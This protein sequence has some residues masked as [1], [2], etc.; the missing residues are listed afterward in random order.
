MNHYQIRTFGD[1]LEIAWTP[2]AWR[3]IGEWVFSFEK[4]GLSGCWIFELG[5]FSVTWNRGDC[6]GA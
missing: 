1:H 6:A 5:F 3:Y 4:C 2:G